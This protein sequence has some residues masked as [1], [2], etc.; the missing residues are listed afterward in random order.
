MK[1]LFPLLLLAGTLL[2]AC[3]LGFGGSD[4]SADDQ[5]PEDTTVLKVGLLPTTDCLPLHYADSAGLFERLGLN[6]EL[7]T[8]TSQMDCDTALARGHVQVA[9][10]EMPRSLLLRHREHVP[11]YLIAQL[12]AEPKFIASKSK[13]IKQVQQL[14]ERL[15]GVA[16]HTAAD[17]FSDFLM[18]SIAFDRA[19]IFRPQINDVKLRTAMIGNG[20][21]DAAFLPEPYA[22]KARLEGHNLLFSPDAS[23][24]HPQMAVLAA[25]TRTCTNAHRA[26]QM[27]NLVRAYNMAADELN[28]RAN[29]ARLRNIMYHVAGLKREV[30]DSLRR[31]HFTPLKAPQRSALD[32]AT[33][34]LQEREMLPASY[35]HADTLLFS[36]FI[37][38]QS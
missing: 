6:V 28:H 5:F 4:S 18:D 3:G 9:R 34:W 25:T 13:E 14:R 16:R 11:H 38:Q 15:V 30:A 31:P 20:T 27:R 23:G 36:R 19:D 1:K 22:T 8:Y 2:T 7:I 35:S 26:E 21:L 24:A 29:P 12:Q 32:A 17:F 37:S 33:R 10:T